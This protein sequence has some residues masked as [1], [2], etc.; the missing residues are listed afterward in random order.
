MYPWSLRSADHI[1]HSLDEN[2]SKMDNL[3]WISPSTP[4]SWLMPTLESLGYR[5][6]L[7]QKGDVGKLVYGNGFPG[8][9]Y[10]L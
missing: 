2:C 8:Q 4:A 9:A 1:S 6:G 5:N 10:W 7:P 3:V